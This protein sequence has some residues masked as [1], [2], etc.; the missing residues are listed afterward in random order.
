LERFTK[1]NP[2]RIALI[3]QI[4]E[5]IGSD[6]EKKIARTQ[7]RQRLLSARGAAVARSFYEGS[8]LRSVLWNRLL[9][10]AISEEMSRR[11]LQVRGSLS[12]SINHEG[13]IVLDLSALSAADQTAIDK[14][15]V[16]STIL[17]E[18]EPDPENIVKSER[19]SENLDHDATAIQRQVDELLSLVRQTGR[20]EERIALLM[21]AILSNPAVG[22]SALLQY[23]RDRAKVATWAITELRKTFVDTSWPSDEKIIAALVPRLLTKQWPMARA[24]LLFFLAKHLGEWP[25]INAAINKALQKTRSIFVDLRRKEIEY[26]LSVSSAPRKNP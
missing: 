11:I 10:A 9:S 1:E 16:V 15:K 3:L 24:E 8:V 23:Q 20:Q 7:M 2:S 25:Q 19:V 22:K 17:L 21:A 13:Q 18:F 26:I 5:L 14:T 4:R 6:R 12:A